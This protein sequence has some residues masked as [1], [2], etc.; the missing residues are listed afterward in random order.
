MFLTR[1]IIF[2]LVVFV[3]LG[4]VAYL[5]ELGHMTDLF[6]VPVLAGFAFICLGIYTVYL[7]TKDIRERR[8]IARARVPQNR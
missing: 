1:R 5:L 3:C 2:V 4:F 7:L 6:Y 8:N